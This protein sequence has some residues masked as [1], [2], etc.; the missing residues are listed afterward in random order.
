MLDY[1]NMNIALGY[2]IFLW[3]L[4]ATLYLSWSLLFLSRAWAISEALL[5]ATVGFWSQILM[6]QLLLSQV[7][8]LHPIPLG[9][10]NIALA[11]ILM[12]FAWFA[13]AP[14]RISARFTIFQSALR[15]ISRAPASLLV[16]LLFILWIV[17]ITILGLILPLYAFDDHSYHGP[18]IA[19]TIQN[20][21]VGPFE[22]S[23]YWIRS[24]PKNSELLGVWNG[25]FCHCDTLIDL[26][27]LPFLPNAA[28]AI[29]VAARRL[30]ARVPGAILAAAV[31]CSAPKMLIQ[32]KTLYNDIMVASLWATGVALVLPSQPNRLVPGRATSMI[33]AGLT[34]GILAGVKY[35]ALVHAV[36]LFLLTLLLLPP[37]SIREGVA[38]VFL[39]VLGAF[40]IGGH[41]YLSNWLT[42]GNPLWPFQIRAGA[43][44]IF[45]GDIDIAAFRET[46]VS[47]AVVS[48]LPGWMRPVFTWLDPQLPF[49]V[50]SR[51][52]GFGALWIVIGIP[53][54]LIWIG[55]SIA[56][57]RLQ[58]LILAGVHVLALALL[59][60]N[61]IPRYVL[62]ML[63]L[64]GC[65]VGAIEAHLAPRAR[66]WLGAVTVVLVA[67]SMFLSL[68]HYFFDVPRLRRFAQL[69]DVQRNAMNF[70]PGVFGETY[71][72]VDSNL[73]PGT[74]VLCGDDVALP[75]P[76]WGT[77][78][79]RRVIWVPLTDP[80]T[81]IN[82]VRAAGAEYA[83]VKTG[84]RQAEALLQAGAVSLFSGNDGWQILRIALETS[85]R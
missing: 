47:L 62:F 64:G 67:L 81:Y 78:F 60:L 59:P 18:I 66:R 26:A 23:I 19:L 83:F 43:S 75:Y 25:I 5:A 45:P 61:W 39:F 71:R 4:N 50:D 17:W 79:E 44:L 55:Y 3:T 15:E 56:L 53:A 28:L 13:G 14:K 12:T 29:Y 40:L 46:D 84:G 52:A 42:F 74:V 34:A 77:R 7:N 27:M 57:G 68:D 33:F 9:L 24:Y 76:L 70:D 54:F 35:I 51:L 16:M 48:A 8:M 80:Q 37:R 69:P 32:S 1:K 65:G 85:Q 6:T 36:G 21:G 31:L 41:W 2:L 73:P 11:G 82:E 72:W 10:I 38:S 63:T 58:S 30:G 20:G 49:T 22:S